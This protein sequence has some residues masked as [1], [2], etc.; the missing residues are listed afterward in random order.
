MPASCALRQGRGRSAPR[1]AA[2]WERQQIVNEQLAQRLALD[3]LHR[4]V[5]QRVGAADVV[6]RDDVGVIEGRGG[7]R[8]LFEAVQSSAVSPPRDGGQD[9]ER[10]LAVQTQVEGAVDLAHASDAEDRDYLIRSKLRSGGD[11]HS[12]G[13]YRATVED[14]PRLSPAKNPTHRRLAIPG[15]NLHQRPRLMRSANIRAMP[16]V[17]RSGAPVNAASSAARSCP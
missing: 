4:H 2:L 11:G 14:G 5:A 12:L 15:W 1:A 7:A 17:M 6:D 9:L 16:S 13:L 10:D 3:E 8:L